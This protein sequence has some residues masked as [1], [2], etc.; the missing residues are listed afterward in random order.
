M[1]APEWMLAELAVRVELGHQ[2][3][4]GQP[5]VVLGFD[6]PLVD[7][8][9]Q[10]LEAGVVRQVDADGQGV[11]KETDEPVDVGVAPVGHRDAHHQVVLAAAHREGDGKDRQLDLEGGDLVLPGPAA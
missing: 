4:K 5:L 7:P 2:A 11:G 3:T 10:G 1:R 8:L 6:H 9:D